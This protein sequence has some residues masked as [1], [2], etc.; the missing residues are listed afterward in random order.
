MSDP[1]YFDDTHFTF[2]NPLVFEDLMFLK[3]CSGDYSRT[4]GALQSFYCLQ[5]NTI[6]YTHTQE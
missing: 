3:A 2:S 5:T 1:Y 6:T 4:H